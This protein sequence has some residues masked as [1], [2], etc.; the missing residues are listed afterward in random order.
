LPLAVEVTRRS[1]ERALDYA[2]NLSPGGLSLH[3][4]RPLLRGEVVA[5]AFALPDGGPRIETR[6]R[7]A[8]SERP[9]RG[10]RVRFCETGVRFEGLGDAERL[11]VARF[12]GAADPGAR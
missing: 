5:L 1:G 9:A 12:V 2:V 3:L 4:A 8:W 10:A 7:V 11:R 6:G